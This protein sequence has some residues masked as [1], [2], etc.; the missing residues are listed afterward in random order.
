MESTEGKTATLLS[1]AAHSQGFVGGPGTSELPCLEA[2]SSLRSTN[3]Q[4]G[5]SLGLPI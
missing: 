4:S 3:Q 1:R 2:F 5:S